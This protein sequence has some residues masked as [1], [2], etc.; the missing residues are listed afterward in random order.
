MI[1][2]PANSP[3]PP[4]H[5]WGRVFWR[6][7]ADRRQLVVTLCLPWWREARPKAL[8][9]IPYAGPIAIYPPFGTREQLMVS[10][11]QGEGWRYGW[12]AR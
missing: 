7:W 10:W 2:V 8:G 5:W 6:V 1:A 9:D 4:L 3:A 12:R 11:R